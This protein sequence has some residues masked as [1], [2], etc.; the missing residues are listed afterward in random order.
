M[1]IWHRISFN[2][3]LNPNLLEKITNLGIN[4][5]KEQLPDLGN[6]G[7][8]GEF[9]YFDIQ[10]N[11]HNW[12]ALCSLITKYK[13]SDISQTFFSE[14]ELLE[15]KWLRLIPT[16]EQG[17]P[18][19]EGTWVRN[20]I[21]YQNVC[22]QCGIFEQKSPFTIKKE[23]NLGKKDFMTLYWT[24]VIFCTTKVLDSLKV[25]LIEGYEVWPVILKK[26]KLPSQLISQLYIPTITRPGLLDT[27]L[28]KTICPTCGTVKFYP[29]TRGVMHYKKNAL[30]THVDM[31]QSYEWFGS[32]HSAYREIIISNKLGQLILKNKWQGVQLKKVKLI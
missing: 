6:L 4:Y 20:P 21:N 9:I 26:T 1:E 8:G 19:P 12:T 18:Q 30:N 25:N 23:L 5:K 15:S 27:E 31:Q 14:K 3:T 2:T 24:Y 17:Y 16:F 10:Q 13:V 29:H 28:K 22:P 32:G 7:I 11:H